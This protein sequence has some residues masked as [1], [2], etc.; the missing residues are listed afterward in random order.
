MRTYLLSF[1]AVLLLTV[2]PCGAEEKA[3]SPTTSE[4]QPVAAKKESAVEC[5]DGCKKADAAKATE[6]KATDTKVSAAGSQ[7]T[8]AKD[9]ATDKAKV[10]EAAGKAPSN[11]EVAKEKAKSDSTDAS[12][13]V[14]SATKS[15]AATATSQ[16]PEK[17]KN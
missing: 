16:T 7:A 8:D 12:G 6:T 14:K 4:K 15:P 10:V 13:N 9:K 5:K 11:P 3:Q 2:A 17:A 1:S